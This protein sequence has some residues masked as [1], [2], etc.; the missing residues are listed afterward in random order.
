M[1]NLQP[2]GCL[3]VDLQKVDQHTGGGQWLIHD[4]KRRHLTPISCKAWNSPAKYPSKV[5][6]CDIN[7]S[8][9][10]DILKQSPGAKT[11]WEV[12]DCRTPKPSVKMWFKTNTKSHKHPSIRL[13]I[14]EQGTIGKLKKTKSGIQHRNRVLQKTPID[15]GG[16]QL[17]Q[18]WRILL[19]Y[20]YISPI[21]ELV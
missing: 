21:T 17:H 19:V 1:S 15:C 8:D 10:S 3:K 16:V 14:I 12:R 18:Y 9:G 7:G 20:V 6:K 2:N 4:T 11:S 13:F 5:A